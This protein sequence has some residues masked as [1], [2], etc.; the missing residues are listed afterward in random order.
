[1][2]M[3]QALRTKVNLV[4]LAVLVLAVALLLGLL[5]LGPS[6]TKSTLSVFGVSSTGD[7]E[8]ARIDAITAA[9][10]NELKAVYTLDWQHA[11]DWGKASQGGATGT[12]LDTLQANFVN[13]KSTMYAAKTTGSISILSFGINK[14]I[15]PS[16]DSKEWTALAFAYVV[17]RESREAFKKV[18][19]TAT[20]PA[21][22][23][24]VPFGVQLDLVQTR[25]G[26]KVSA[27]TNDRT[28]GD[29]R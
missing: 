13:Y 12:L 14:I 23:L 9:G 28:S 22:T 7:E 3:L 18:T 27:L 29:G 17:T 6:A 1:M 26:W 5:T 11:D 4:L 15:P 2:T 16:G 25:D 20:C 10:E 19:A 21:A 24:C 8:Q